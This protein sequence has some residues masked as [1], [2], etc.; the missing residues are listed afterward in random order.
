D[1]AFININSGNPTASI[2]A[3]LALAVPTG[4]NPA[5]TLDI[6]NGGT[7][8]LR[9]SPG[10]DAGL[11]S[12]LFVSNN[13]NIGI[14]TTAPSATLEILQANGAPGGILLRSSTA[15]ATNKQ[16]RI[17]T[18]HY[19]VSEEPITTFLASNTNTFNSLAIGGSSSTENAVT[20]LVFYTA[21]T[22][23]TTT[24]NI[25]ML[26]DGQ[27]N[28]GIGTNV[29]LATLD[30]RYNSGTVPVAS[31]SAT[32]SYAAFTVDQRG[33]GDIFVASNAGV[34]RF[35]LQS[36]GNLGIGV[37]LPNQRL[38]VA[39]NIRIAGGGQ[40]FVG[41][42]GGS[43]VSTASCVTTTGGIVTGS[44]SCP[45]GA[46][47]NWT[48]SSGAI[49]PNQ[50]SVLDLL[51]GGTSTAS[52][53]FAFINVNSGNP[54]ASISGNLALA[55]PTGNA[56][57]ITLDLLNNPTFNIRQSVG[58][59]GG[60][61]SRF[62]INQ[63]GNIG[64]GT[65]APNANVNLVG[66]TDRTLRL[67]TYSDSPEINGILQFVHAGGTEAS[68]TVT[69]VDDI[70]GEIE[71]GGYDTT[72]STNPIIEFAADAGWG[73]AGDSTDEPTRVVFYT[74]PDGSGTSVER[75]RITGEGNIGIGTA[76]PSTA[77]V[78]KLHVQGD[79]GGVALVKFN[80]LGT[81]D[82]F[83]ASAA[84]TTRF[85]IKNDGNVGIGTVLPL[86]TL[87][88]A[89]TARITTSFS[90]FDDRSLCTEAASGDIELKNG[91]CGTSAL[92][93][94]ENIEGMTYGLDE[95]NLLNPVFFNYKN[96]DEQN[97]GGRTKRR[98]GFIAEEMQQVVPEVV[99]LDEEGLADSIDYAYLVSML[100]KG[101]QE[102]DSRTKGIGTSE[103]GNIIATS[104]SIGIGTTTPVGLLHVEGDIGWP[105][106]VK[107]NNTSSVGDIFTASQGGT[108][109]F[110]IKNDGNVGIGTTTPGAALDIAGNLLVNN[111]AFIGNLQ[112]GGIDA[113]TLILGGKNILDL[114]T[115]TDSTTSAEL[116]NKVVV[117][118]EKVD[119][120]TSKVDLI[121]QLSQKLAS[122]TAF[123]TDIL[124]NQLGVGS[125][126]ASLEE[127][128]A[129]TDM[130][131]GVFSGE[132]TVLGR[133]TLSDL[134]V[135]GNIT[136]GLLTING[137]E[138]SINT[139]GEP[140]KLQ[141][142]GLE[143]LEIMAGKVEID[144]KGNVTTKGEVTAKKINVD[145]TES[146]STALGSGVLKAG[147]TS[148]RIETTAVTTNSKVFITATS[149]TGKQ[150]LI[151][152]S[153]QPGSSLRVNVEEAF[154]KDI[155]FDWWIVN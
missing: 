129:S 132:L 14:G 35:V 50:A 98:I 99:L 15:D 118:G 54:T 131:D 154:S 47:S 67:T 74:V 18:G 22:T 30:V 92:R 104:G 23:T 80:E 32:T 114:F 57:A 42:T 12:R 62:Y 109:K 28:V 43:T 59:D 89:G 110:V 7:L 52:A 34:N 4:T 103:Q 8:S 141:P 11:S 148:V 152:D 137:L 48:I 85:V 51:L 155:T 130:K 87:H 96:F 27:G 115:T 40:Y 116:R 24:G 140:L 93:Y 69:I 150:T 9:T 100:T 65:T 36:A 60:V 125:T 145:T 147:Q 149:P 73:T 97:P 124:S 66:T 6:L 136:A 77:P 49:F 90:V 64:I 41:T 19:T 122:Q 113:K 25:R 83:T 16:G 29:P 68:P 39:G 72:L 134:G 127:S 101:V 102:L 2:S 1:F 151:V 139:I 120:L 78:G 58:G 153:K 3:N 46:G 45:G 112:A 56:P 126:S 119:T 88:V 121:D 5:A 37:P 135:T 21:P 38:E 79:A 91:A 95:I 133:T 82:I 111:D 70:L 128:I 142:L 84:G 108:T 10:G 61:T 63:Q 146:Q 76:T 31:F 55:V 44:G 123:L 138:G 143:K 17:K 71:A 106:L 13:G 94:K 26:I 107:F 117:L 75:M 81:N 53:D 105:A 20:E 144:T 33:A 86:Q